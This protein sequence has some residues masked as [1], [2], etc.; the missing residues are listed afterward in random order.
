MKI[1]VR[2]HVLLTALT[3][4]RENAQAHGQE[5]HR[6]LRAEWQHLVL[7]EVQ[8]RLPRGGASMLKLAGWGSVG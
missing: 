5:T 4:W 3:E 6:E 7:G 8:G 2:T 1:C